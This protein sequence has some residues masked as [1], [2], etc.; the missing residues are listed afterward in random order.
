MARRKKKRRG[1]GPLRLLAETSRFHRTKTE[2]T[3]TGVVDVQPD[4]IAPRMTYLHFGPGLLE[5]GPLESW[6]QLAQLRDS[7]H[8]VWIDVDGLGSAEAI[9]QIGQAFRLHPLAMED[10]VHVHQRPKVDDYGE[11]LF[12]VARMASYDNQLETEQLGMFLGRNFV[13]TFQ[14]GRPGDC[15]ELVRQRLRQ[16]H[17]GLRQSGADYLAYSLLDAVIDG[18]FP[19]VE[20]YGD[21][22]N[23][24]DDRLSSLSASVPLADIHDIRSEL[25]LLRRAAWPHR[26]A[27]NHLLREEYSLIK[28]ETR[29]YL[30]DCYDHMLQIIDVVE[31]YREMC[32]D[33]RDFHLSAASHRAGEIMKVLTII[34]TIFIPLSFIAGLYGMNFDFMPELR[35][36]LG[37]LYALTLMSGVGLALVWFVW[38]RGWFHR[39]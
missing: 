28:P 19:I 1:K 21:R 34:S 12:I 14:E 9:R 5:E 11:H 32:S 29:V 15:F 35:W 22:L 2:G 10:V 16:G 13:V 17:G 23:Q 6:Q 24:L 27:V 18:Y 36:R 37:Y 25:L 3:V 20:A 33:L 31:T 38:R 7:P 8:V 4:A 26:E 30:R 39:W